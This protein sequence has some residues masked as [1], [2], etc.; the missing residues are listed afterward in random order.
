MILEYRGERFQ[1]VMKA[2]R[3]RE[4]DLIFPVWDSRNRRFEYLWA[5]T[6]GGEM[7]SLAGEDV[8]TQSIFQMYGMQGND[9]YYNNANKDIVKWNI[10]SGERTKILNLPKNGLVAGLQ[11]L[12]AL[13]GEGDQ[14]VL[15]LVDQSHGKEWLA[16]LTDQEIPDR[17]IVRVADLVMDRDYGI[18]P[19]AD[20]VSEAAK[21]NRDF[22]YRYEDDSTEEARTRVLAD[23]SSG[24]GPDLMYVSL[25]D[26]RMLEE[27]GALL[28]MRELLP[29]ARV[30]EML[31]GAVEIGT[32]DG[33]FVGIPMQ[34]EA[35]TLMVARDT[36]SE[37]SWTLEDIIR[38]ME[39]G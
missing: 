26:M 30:E 8:F 27:K 32:I 23:L 18:N 29:E 35:Y 22:L 37:D 39:I 6:E 28:D 24:N 38:L 21:L 33:K 4:G 12:M 1:I 15:C 31:P 2:L 34:V 25:E 10:E 11:I 13:G 3:T 16:L 5:D 7:R 36:W 9:I 19:A 17:E 20:S 14:P